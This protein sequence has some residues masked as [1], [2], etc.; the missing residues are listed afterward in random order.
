MDKLDEQVIANTNQIA[1]NRRQ[2]RII[3]ALLVFIIGGG[4]FLT[5]RDY[6]EVDVKFKNRNEPIEKIIPYVD[7]ELTLNLEK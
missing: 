4:T 7:P 2:L 1:Y 3:V 5:L 6:I